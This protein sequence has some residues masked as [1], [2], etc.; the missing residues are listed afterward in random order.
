MKKDINNIVFTDEILEK[1][2]ADS[3]K[4]TKLCKKID[5]NK[6]IQKEYKEYLK[7]LHS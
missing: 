4:I 1:Y 6:K 7:T 2:K 3:E 5:K